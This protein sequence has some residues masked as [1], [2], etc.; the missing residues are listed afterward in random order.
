MKRPQTRLPDNRRLDDNHGS[1]IMRPS[2]LLLAASAVTL[3]LLASA[4]TAKIATDVYEKRATDYVKDKVDEVLPEGVTIQGL[5]DSKS[6][7]SQQKSAPVKKLG[8]TGLADGSGEGS[9]EGSGDGSGAPTLSGTA[10]PIAPVNATPV[11]I[12]PP[13]PVTSWNAVTFGGG[14]GLSCSTAIIITGASDQMVG[15]QAEYHWLGRVYPGYKENRFGQGLCGDK[16]THVRE[17][18]TTDGKRFEVIFDISSFAP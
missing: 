8:Q 10:K 1:V 12:A 6:G 3:G 4:C 2:S 14:N 9:G 17:I 18:T 13:R 5:N 15:S 11:V 7:S 16:K